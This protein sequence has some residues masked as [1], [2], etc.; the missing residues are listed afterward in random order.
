[1]RGLRLPRPCLRSREPG[2]KVFGDRGENLLA[3][4]L[5]VDEE[6]PAGQDA[7]PE[8][9]ARMLAPPLEVVVRE[10]AVVAP[11][12]AGPGTRQRAVPAGA[13]SSRGPTRGGGGRGG[14]APGARAP[15]A[16]PRGCRRSAAASPPRARR[17][18]G[19]SPA[20]AET[21][22]EGPRARTRRAR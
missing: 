3:A 16:P 19:A 22:G 8:R 5:L 14:A 10:V 12:A 18:R 7:E 11:R 20:V 6:V 17:R 1:R 15:R 2:P 9:L 21:A 13:R 4:L